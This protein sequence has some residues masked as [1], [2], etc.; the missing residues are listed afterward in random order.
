[1]TGRLRW[2]PLAGALVWVGQEFL[3]DRWPFHGFPWARL[4]FG[5]ADGPMV[6]LAALGGAPL[7]SFA[8][9]SAGSLLALAVAGGL[10]RRR[11]VGAA[12]L[13]GAAVVVSAPLAMTL[14]TAGTS[15]H[16]SPSSAV[17]AAVQGNVP[18]LGL[19]EFAQRYAVTQDHLEE[20]R[21]LAREVA[22]GRLPRPQIVV[23]PENASDE[24]PRTDPVARAQIDAAAAAVGV[25]MLVGA[26]LDGPGPHHVQNAGIVWSPISGPGDMYLKRHLVPFGEYLPFR[27][28]LSRLVG[29]FSL[30]P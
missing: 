22:A 30:I 6:R 10:Q 20:T 29:E 4:A 3:R 21:L 25:P 15:E 14:P 16:G 27:S 11:I 19:K 1:M 17:V 7:V 26:V 12:A 2:W 9:A 28:V 18:R 24:D 5:Q 8:V 13:A 23:W